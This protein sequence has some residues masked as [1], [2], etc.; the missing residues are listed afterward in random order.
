[1]EIFSTLHF[2]APLKARFTEPHG[3]LHAL[4]LQEGKDYVAILVTS[5]YG[6]PEVAGLCT[7]IDF[8]PLTGPLEGGV[9]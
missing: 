7:H 2:G 4:R 9:V 5:H 1:M 3:F 8:S 6:D